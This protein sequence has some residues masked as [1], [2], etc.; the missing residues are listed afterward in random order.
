[1]DN[2]LQTAFSLHHETGCRVLGVEY[3]PAFH[4]AAEQNLREYRGTSAGIGFVLQDAERFEVP[5]ESE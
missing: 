2:K 4:A 5:D 1:M 3:S